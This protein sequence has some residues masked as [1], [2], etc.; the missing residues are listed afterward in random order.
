MSSIRFTRRQAFG[1]A[2]LGLGSVALG[3]R[4][5][6]DGSLGALHHAPRLKGIDRTMTLVDG[7]L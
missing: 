6:A 1:A 5:S 7:T 4:A 2:G 3:R